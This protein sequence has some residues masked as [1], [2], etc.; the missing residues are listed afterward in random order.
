MVLFELQPHPPRI[1]R[2]Q[3][4]VRHCFLVERILRFLLVIDIVIYD[5]HIK[6]FQFYICQNAAIVYS[7]STCVS[8]W[9]RQHTL[10]NPK[11][12]RT[13]PSGVFSTLVLVKYTTLSTDIPLLDFIFLTSVWKYLYL[14]ANTPPQVKH[15]IGIIIVFRL[16]I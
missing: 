10:C 16:V 7:I 3:L 11:L 13:T 5:S 14:S 12:S 8:M 9:R 1:L 6:K 2:L 4:L 15:L